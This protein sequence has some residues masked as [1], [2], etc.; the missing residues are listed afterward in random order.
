MA[1][2][3]FT[4]YSHL[5]YLEDFHRDHGTVSL[6]LEAMKAFGDTILIRH[7]AELRAESA[8]AQPLDKPLPPMPAHYALLHYLNYENLKIAA[9][10]ELH[11]KARLLA[12]D[13]VLH[14]IDRKAG[15]AYKA[16]ADKQESEPVSK[17]ELTALSPY[18]SNQTSR[19]LPGLRDSSL[20]FE[21]LVRKQHYI[22]ALGLTASEAGAIDDYRRL[23]NGIHL[24]GDV[25]DTPHLAALGMPAGEFLLQFINTNIVPRVNGLITKHAFN[26]PP[27]QLLV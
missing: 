20:G 15:P 2:P 27:L 7:R 9:A 22:S 1:Q 8:A 5:I 3:G 23:R 14:L 13:F 25:L 10:F 21:L 19:Y 4:G 26:W 17:A 16:L 18:V 24:P 11:L 6:N 12:Q